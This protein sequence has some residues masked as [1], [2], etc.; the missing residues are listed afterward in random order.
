MAI[1]KEAR[2]AWHPPQSTKLI[3]PNLVGSGTKTVEADDRWEGGG[4]TP[5]RRWTNADYRVPTSGEPITHPNPW[6]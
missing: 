4:A 5:Q 3:A 2:A 6:Q 1:D